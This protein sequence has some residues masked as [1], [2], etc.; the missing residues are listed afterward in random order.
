MEIAL[1][2]I[3]VCLHPIAWVLYS[4]S[5]FCHIITKSEPTKT[6]LFF[7]YYCIFMISLA[8]EALVRIIIYVHD[9]RNIWGNQ[10]VI[11]FIFLIVSILVLCFCIFTLNNKYASIIARNSYIYG[12]VILTLS[13]MIVIF[14]ITSM[15]FEASYQVLSAYGG[16]LA[17]LYGL[18]KYSSIDKEITI[19]DKDRIFKN[20]FHFC[21]ILAVWILFILHKDL[22]N[23]INTIPDEAFFIQTIRTKG[24]YSWAQSEFSPSPSDTIDV[25][26][27]LGFSSSKYFKSGAVSLFLKDRTY[28]VKHN[29]EAWRYCNRGVP[30]LFRRVYTEMPLEDYKKS[31]ANDNSNYNSPAFDS[32]YDGIGNIYFTLIY[33]QN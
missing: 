3:D 13:M 2:F 29:I 26:V 9:E 6:S 5:F 27:R 12:V 21:I 10:E 15:I 23:P 22:T 4:W 8:I 14:S 1:F 25:T 17:A 18:S 7:K 11:L 19:P 32:P 20:I 28:Y 16:T 33:R 24:V 31:L 30:L